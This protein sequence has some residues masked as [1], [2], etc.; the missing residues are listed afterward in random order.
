[1]YGVVLPSTYLLGVVGSKGADVV[2]MCERSVAG[3][4]DEGRYSPIS[5][6]INRHYLALKLRN[7]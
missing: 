7:P 2:E 1:M 5:V 6:H 4:H 3:I